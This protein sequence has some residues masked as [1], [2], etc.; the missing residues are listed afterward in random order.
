MSVTVLPK[1]EVF[2][3]IRTSLEFKEDIINNI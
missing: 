2:N 3:E 1:T